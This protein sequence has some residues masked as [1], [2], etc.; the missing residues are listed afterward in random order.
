MQL[1]VFLLSVK[2]CIVASMLPLLLGIF[3]Y[4]CVAYPM[5]L[6][7]WYVYRWFSV[8]RWCVASKMLY[9]DVE[10]VEQLLV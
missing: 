10:Q 1:L 7:S 2:P 5:Y 4:Q 3:S 8:R 9:Q 6:A